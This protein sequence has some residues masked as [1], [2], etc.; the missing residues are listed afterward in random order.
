M[1]QENWNFKESYE[2]LYWK[3]FNWLASEIIKV[4][5]Y[6]Y[7]KSNNLNLIS[8]LKILWEETSFKRRKELYNDLISKND[9]YEW[10]ETQNRELLYK[11]ISKY[12]FKESEII[13][14]TS[15]KKEELKE[16]I[17]VVKNSAV[18]NQV[19]K[20]NDIYETKFENKIWNKNEVIETKIETKN[21]E[22]NIKLY[23]KWNTLFDLLQN[24]WLDTSIKYR[25]DLYIAFFWE[26][27]KYYWT[28]EQNIELFNKLINFW[29]IN[30]A[31]SKPKPKK[32]KTVLVKNEK[33]KKININSRPKIEDEKW[34]TYCSITSEKNLLS[35][36]VQPEKR[37][38]AKKIMK[39][40]E[41]E[42]NLLC[43][44]LEEA[45]KYI[46][47]KFQLWEA[48]TFEIF[49]KTQRWHRAVAYMWVWYNI[50]IL[51]PYYN[52]NT[53]K[54]IPIDEYSALKKYD[55][56][57]ISKTDYI[58]PKIDNMINLAS[59]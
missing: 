30:I 15:L 42:W 19:I 50:Y 17:E 45:K 46:T 22:N 5:S 43:L 53:Q 1:S 26:D 40:L 47:D 34:M 18:N 59:Q 27:K 23:N 48:N 11:L 58:S 57:Y 4:K 7:I 55:K 38:W 20:Q 41:K 28:A 39:E 54:P 35:L 44:N 36:Q 32:E 56:I 51:D 29:E 10:Y 31:D 49:I 16:E 52:W 12:Y 9:K 2:N 21:N 14:E 3:T 13:S 6:E 37:W 24:N 33:P 8:Y 25:K